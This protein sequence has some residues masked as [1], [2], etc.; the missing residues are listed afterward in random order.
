VAG[1]FLGAVVYRTRSL[2]TATMAHFAWNLTLAVFLHAAVSGQE[3]PAGDYRVIDS[4]PDWATGGAW[5]PEGGAAAV[6]GMLTALALLL[7]WRR[8]GASEAS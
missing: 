3:M 1:I 8:R 4:G 5:G 6:V 7:R 2:W